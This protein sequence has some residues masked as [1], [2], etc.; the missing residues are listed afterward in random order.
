MQATS[1]FISLCCLGN[2]ALI[3]G[4]VA[5]ESAPVGLVASSIGI[6]VGAGEIFGGGV[7]PLIGGFIA[8]NFGINNV[9]YLALF[10]VA[11]GAVI[12]FFLKETSPASLKKVQLAKA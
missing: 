11:L 1:F 3:T 10:G 9:L 8:E 7:A 2:I 4:P 12:S 6:V 5:T